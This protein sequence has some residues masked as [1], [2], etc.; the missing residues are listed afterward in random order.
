MLEAIGG[1]LDKF[2]EGVGI[3]EDAFDESEVIDEEAL[4]WYNE[5]FAMFVADGAKEAINVYVHH[6]CIRDD[7]NDLTKVA[8]LQ[9]SLNA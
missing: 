7:L 1:N 6:A 4:A 2:L 3:S 5:K 8:I 9:A